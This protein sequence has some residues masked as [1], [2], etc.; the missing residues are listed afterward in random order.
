MLALYKKENT[1]VV[2]DFSRLTRSIKDLL[3]HEVF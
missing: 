1:I 3:Q 2:H